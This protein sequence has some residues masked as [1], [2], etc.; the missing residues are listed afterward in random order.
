MSSTLRTNASALSVS[1]VRGMG[2]WAGFDA[3][4]TLA[5]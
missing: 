1:V 5:A 3:V 4:P 2:N